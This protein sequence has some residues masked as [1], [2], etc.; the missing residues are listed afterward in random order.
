MTKSRLLLGGGLLVACVGLVIEFFAGVVDF[1]TIPP[2]PFILGISGIIV[3]ALG[4]ARWPLVLGFVA[5]LFI[6][7]GGLIEGSVWGRIADPGET[8]DWIGVLLQWPGQVVALVAGA[9]AIRKAYLRRRLSR[10]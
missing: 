6:T 8:A 3:F 5:A 9:L 4:R 2:G 7:V 10:V 1:P